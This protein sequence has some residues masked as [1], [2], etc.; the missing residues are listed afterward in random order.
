VVTGIF[1]ELDGSL[2]CPDL[3]PLLEVEVRGFSASSDFRTSSEKWINWTRF[4]FFI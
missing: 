2:A 4:L 3:T 1:A